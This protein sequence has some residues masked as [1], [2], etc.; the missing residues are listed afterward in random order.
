MQSFLIAMVTKKFIF[1]YTPYT[2]MKSRENISLEEWIVFFFSLPTIFWN[3]EKRIDHFSLCLFCS[4]TLTVPKITLSSIEKEK[5][6]FFSQTIKFVPEPFVF[7][8][9]KFF[10]I[11][12][13]LE[14][15]TPQLLIIEKKTR[16]STLRIFLLNLSR[17][18]LQVAFKNLRTKNVLRVL[19]HPNL[20]FGEKINFALLPKQF[21]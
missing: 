11:T 2:K 4:E 5:N 16:M 6:C 9:V 7:E 21:S 18:C 1:G 19:I 12:M 8:V 14:I 20:I 17:Y 3:F 13:V 15:L 10:F